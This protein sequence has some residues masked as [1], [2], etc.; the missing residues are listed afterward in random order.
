MFERLRHLRS[1]VR[2]RVQDLNPETGYQRIDPDTGERRWR[3][4]PL[5]DVVDDLTHS[6]VHER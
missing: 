2:I 4:K 5:A 6:L 3:S 1:H